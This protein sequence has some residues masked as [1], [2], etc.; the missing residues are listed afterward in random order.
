[1]IVL[2]KFG[3][4]L[5]SDYIIL[6]LPFFDDG[7]KLFEFSIDIDEKLSNILNEFIESESHIFLELYNNIWNFFILSQK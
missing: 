6:S 5:I 3:W 4:M 2:I 1:M 7:G